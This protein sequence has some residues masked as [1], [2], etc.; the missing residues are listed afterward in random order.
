MLS[1]CPRSRWLATGGW[2]NSGS[3][4]KL[5]PGCN[6]SPERWPQIEE[7]VQA[8]LDCRLEDRAVFLDRACGSDH[9]LRREVESL[10]VVQA[11]ERFAGESGFA[12]ALRVLE[13]RSTALNQGRRIGAYR[14]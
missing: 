1:K 9:E 14:V 3:G 6:M 8:A 10:L 12:D 2:P 7:I 4:V 5:L 13:Q 11:D